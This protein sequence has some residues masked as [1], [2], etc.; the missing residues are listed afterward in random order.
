MP[1][2]SYASKELAR[3]SADY[4]QDHFDALLELI[5]FTQAHPTTLL[6]AKEKGSNSMQHPMP[7]GMGDVNTSARQVLLFFTVITPSAG[8]HA[9]S[10]TRPD[11]SVRVS[12][13]H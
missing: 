11:R 13:W 8:L 1:S 9:L 3:F 6:I 4:R 10:A 12:L 7:T 2:V 5:T